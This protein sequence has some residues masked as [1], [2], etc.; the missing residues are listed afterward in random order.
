MMKNPQKRNKSAFPLLPELS[1]KIFRE[2]KIT[3]IP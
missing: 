3:A 2:L 1:G